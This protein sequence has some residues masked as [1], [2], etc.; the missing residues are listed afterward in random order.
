[1]PPLRQSIRT[2][3]RAFWIL[4][5]ATF[6]NKFG[7]FVVPF[8]TVFVTRKGFSAADAGLAAGAYPVGSFGAAM[9]GGWLA[10]RIGRNATMALASLSGAVC[11]LFLSQAS[12]LEWLVAL[13]FLTGLCNESGNSAGNALIQDMIPAEHRMNAFTMLRFCVNLAWSFGPGVA[14][15]IAKYSF[16]WLFVGDAVTSIFFG[17]TALWFLPHG[18]VTAKDRTGWPVALRHIFSNHAFLALA[19]AQIFLA[20]NFRQITTSFPLHLVR[21]GHDL[22]FYGYVQMINGIMVCALELALLTLTRGGSTRVF[23]ALGYVVLGASYLL[24]FFGTGAWVFI[25]VMFV[26]TLGEMFAFS[27]QPAYLSILSHDEMRGRYHGFLSLTWCIGSSSSAVLGLRLYGWK[28]EAAWVLCAM[29]G[30]M[31]AACVL[32]RKPRMDAN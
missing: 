29:F 12:A 31:A 19:A 20:F 21:S 2:F 28:P 11:M 13:S 18:S 16:F 15:I 3:P 8:L 25:S 17:L 6:V 7:V 22:D 30:I 24:F 14:G 9:I 5:G 27:R 1:M 23:L 4:A 10:D 26:F 32:G